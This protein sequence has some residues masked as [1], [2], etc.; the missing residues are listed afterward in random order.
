MLGQ[1][2]SRMQSMTIFDIYVV[3]WLALMPGLI[4]HTLLLLCWLPLKLKR[5]GSINIVANAC[6]D[7]CATLTPLCFSIDGLAGDEGHEANCFCCIWH[8][9]YLVPVWDHYS[10]Q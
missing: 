2:D 1:F 6:F 10:V 4:C 7:C 9:V 3:D 8:S 5:N